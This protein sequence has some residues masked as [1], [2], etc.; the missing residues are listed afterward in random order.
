M[1]SHAV[2][3]T[4]PSGPSNDK[5]LGLRPRFLSTES[6]GPCFSDGMGDHDQILQ[7]IVSIYPLNSQSQVIIDKYAPLILKIRKKSYWVIMNTR[8]YHYHNGAMS[9]ENYN[10]HY[11][12]T[13]AIWRFFFFAHSILK[14]SHAWQNKRKKKETTPT[15]ITWSSLLK[16]GHR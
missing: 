6:L 1:I 5:N 13:N 16:L 12:G 4:W 8:Y 14:H 11:K 15:Q 2:W 3:K 10:K 7:H 9:C